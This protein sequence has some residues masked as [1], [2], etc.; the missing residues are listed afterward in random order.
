MQNIDEFVDRLLSE[1]GIHDA[2]P[3]YKD[4]LK[5]KI[6]D[7]IDE[8][9]LEELSDERV[10]ELARLVDDPTFDGHK[11]RD[12]IIRAGVDVDDVAQATMQT[13]R[14]QFLLGGQNE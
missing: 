12:Y 8:A 3:N 5:E 7:Q 6:L 9:A 10:A 4:E 13:F 2:D 1:K 14:A 11:M